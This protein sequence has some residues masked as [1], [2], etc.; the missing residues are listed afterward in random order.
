MSAGYIVSG[1]ALSPRYP[2]KITPSIIS[3]RAVNT[4]LN[5]PTYAQQLCEG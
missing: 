2:L 4:S 3:Q 1:N 5:T